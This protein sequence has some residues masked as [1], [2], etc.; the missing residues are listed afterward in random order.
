[1]CSKRMEKTME[2]KPEDAECR[3]PPN[4]FVIQIF[5]NN[6]ESRQKDYRLFVQ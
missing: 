1:M 6:N 2:R 3:E 5:Y 4:I